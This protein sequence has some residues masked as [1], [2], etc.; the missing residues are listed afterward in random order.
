MGK[1]YTFG[2]KTLVQKQIPENIC[3]VLKSKD[4]EPL[5]KKGKDFLFFSL[6]FF[7]PKSNKSLFIGT[8]S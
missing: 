4:L 5:L 8:G 3:P 2:L 6:S 7:P 1:L